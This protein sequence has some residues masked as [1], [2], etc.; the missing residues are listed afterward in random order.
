MEDILLFSKQNHNMAIEV[1]ITEYAGKK[2]LR[3]QKV[4]IAKTGKKYY[5]ASFQFMLQYA[6][7]II[8]QLYE[9]LPIIE[10]ENQSPLDSNCI[11][12]GKPT[13]KEKKS[14]VG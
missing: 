9:A 10:K 7:D 3:I 11:T 6:P 4:S 14:K 13:T 1:S 5:K 2:L 12:T 8:K